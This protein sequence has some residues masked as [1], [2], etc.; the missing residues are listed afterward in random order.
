MI[1]LHLHVRT[2]LNNSQ[3]YFS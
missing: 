2:K 3:N 1:T